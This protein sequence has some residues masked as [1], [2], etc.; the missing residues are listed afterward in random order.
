MMCTGYK[1]PQHT[2]EQAQ[3]GWERG[4]RAYKMKCITPAEDT[5]EK[6]IRYDTDG[7]AT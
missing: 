4:F 3:W 1:T 5:P 6:R 2:A 7:C